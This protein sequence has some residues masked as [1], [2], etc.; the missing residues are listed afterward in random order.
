MLD[1]ADQRI[2]VDV[3]ESSTVFL[4]LSIHTPAPSG[5]PNMNP[6]GG[7]ITGS[8]KAGRVHQCFQ[9][10][11]TLP[12]SGLPVAWHDPCTQRQNFAGQSFDLHPW[13]DEESAMVDDRLQIA[14]PLLVAPPDSGVAGLH[15]PGG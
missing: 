5:L 15:P 12:I 3:F 4:V 6:V 10:Q 8:A 7:P 2:D 11:R 13:Q 9:E 14:L 1:I